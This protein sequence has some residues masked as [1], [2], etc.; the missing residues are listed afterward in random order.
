[1]FRFY[2]FSKASR[3]NAKEPN[4][5]L[6]WSINLISEF[7]GTIFISI[8]FAGL[9][10]LINGRKLGSYM[11]NDVVVGFYA[12][13]A[14]IGPA[15]L[16]FGHWSADMNPINSIYKIINGRDTVLY[17]MSKIIVQFFGG[18]SAG[19][20]IY[21]IGTWT[22]DGNAANIAISAVEVAKKD[23]LKWNNTGQSALIG[24]SGWIFFGELTVAAIF[25]FPSFT[26]RLN[27]RNEK[28]RTIMKMFIFSLCVWT[29]S[30]IGSTAINPARGLAQQIPALFFGIKDGSTL[31]G[32]TDLILSTIFLVLGGCF[33]PLFY[34]LVQGFTETYFNPLIN[35]IFYYHNRSKLFMIS[36]KDKLKLKKNKKNINNK[37][38]YE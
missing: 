9:S 6:T 28:Y 34:A 26:P 21:T 22:N 32:Q 30:L 23:F 19:L 12:G 1:M 33:A 15:S 16:F 8:A 7:F 10:I 31:H 36:N 17:G 2:H 14:V 29:G 25:L 37:Q 35:K 11:L 24:G 13:F 4:D 27:G 3:E 5:L 38:K 20:M 18:I